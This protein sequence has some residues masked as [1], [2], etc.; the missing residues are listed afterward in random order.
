M[1]SRNDIWYLSR[2]IEPVPFDFDLVYVDDVFMTANF[3]M[4][5]I[6]AKLV[7]ADNDDENIRIAYP[8]KSAVVF[9]FVSIESKN[10]QLITSVCHKPAAEPCVLSYLSDHSRYIHRN[11][12][13][14]GLFVLLVSLPMSTMVTESHW[15]WSWLW[16]WIVIGAPR[17]DQKVIPSCSVPYCFRDVQSR[18]VSRTHTPVSSHNNPKSANILEFSSLIQIIY[19]QHY[20]S[21]I[22]VPAPNN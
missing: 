16:S 7:H 13:Y 18:T 1:N 14:G 5:W 9:F 10:G 3:S 15:N 21:S 4:D 6:K 19:W 11:T 12:A 8:V 22:S 20:N 2:L 17:D